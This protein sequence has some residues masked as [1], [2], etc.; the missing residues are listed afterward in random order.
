MYE[1]TVLANGQE[2]V[3]FITIFKRPHLNGVILDT[4]FK[5]PITVSKAG[6][7]VFS[8][9]I[10]TEISKLGQIQKFHRVD[11]GDDADGLIEAAFDDK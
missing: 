4:N 6:E 10:R 7:D 2:V 8:A 9:Q 11:L 3:Y 5:N 1:I